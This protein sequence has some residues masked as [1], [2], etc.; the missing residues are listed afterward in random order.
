MSQGH[1]RSELLIR[2]QEARER[3]QPL[4]P[5][6]LCRDYPELLPE[7][8]REIA[9]LEHVDRLRGGDEPSSVS[10]PAPP[11]PC[12]P[13][14]R[15]SPPVAAAAAPTLIPATEPA[16]PP[17]S[18]ATLP[19]V[20][21]YEI[22]GT[23]GHGGMGMV[24][25]ARQVPLNRLVAL[26]MLRADVAA[27]P[28]ERARFRAEAETVARLQHPNIVQIYD[29]GEHEGRPF[30]SLELL[31]GGSLA[32]RLGGQALPPR[33]AAQLVEVL[34][35]AMHAAHEH[36]VV[37]RDLKPSNILLAGHP[38]TPLPQCVPKITDFGL[39]KRLDGSEGLT[40]SGT[41]MGTPAYMAPEQAA[42]HNRDI[43]PPCDIYGLGA[44]LYE[45][46]TG[47]PPFKAPTLLATIEQV[48]AV[49]PIPPTQLAP[50]VPR[51]LETICLKCLQKERR[52]RYATAQDLAEDLSRYL[53][54]EPIRA[55][56][57]GRWERGLR[58]LRR[59][60]GAA[61]LAA[62]ST[63]TLAG[64]VAGSG[65]SHPLAAVMAGVL[66]LLVAAWW[67]NA[68]LQAALNEAREQQAMAERYVER[69]H[70]LLETA[71][72]LVAAPDTDAL[73]RLLG[74]TAT[75]LAN[76]DRAT[77]YLVDPQRRE[78]WSR[79]ALGDRV[80]EIR[81]PLGKG[82]AGTVASTG[83]IINLPVAEADARFN[84]EID[85]RTGYK[86][87][88]MLTLPMV[89]PQGRVVGVFQLLNK[90]GGP[91]TGED[92]EILSLL[93]T[94]ASVAVDKAQRARSGAAARP[95]AAS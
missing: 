38:D 71:R 4:T 77:I 69:L 72:E 7:L 47:R 87:R 14:G 94:S 82:I 18:S 39:V 21:G 5:E 93:A 62:I 24:Y 56:P 17:A 44:I 52:Q 74:E 26:K 29:L 50:R 32:R 23:L 8:R 92:V 95:E 30:F 66:S 25:R 88:N 60:P 83:E 61:L 12:W 36:G 67:Y 20:T 91:F 33:Q 34:A 58:W 84:P 27:G 40:I 78:L 45:C 63:A 42:G 41:V 15:A 9:L 68:R 54:G 10:P 53:A 86:T 37:H 85:R 6:E 19:R 3:G 1:L 90:R 65:W 2:W 43:G 64:I 31:E 35:R 49:D 11:L 55:R 79:I 28:G 16:G 75:R 73:L 80:G 13:D 46:L 48:R 76:A 81:L 70:L 89:S 59:R 57:V 51:D 22:L